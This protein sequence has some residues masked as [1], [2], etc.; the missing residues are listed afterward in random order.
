MYEY[1]INHL[2]KLRTDILTTFPL[3]SFKNKNAILTSQNHKKSGKSHSFFNISTPN[4]DKAEKLR[5]K[6]GDQKTFS[7]D[8]TP[9]QVL[10]K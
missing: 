4:V 8:K 6:S 2:C 3:K 1:S 7:S 10:Q 5:L 9:C